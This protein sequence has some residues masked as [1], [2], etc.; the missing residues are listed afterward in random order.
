MVLGVIQHM[1]FVG[2]TMQAITEFKNPSAEAWTNKLSHLYNGVP[3]RHKGKH[4]TDTVT[5]MRVSDT[6][7]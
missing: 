1:N 3:C 2:D 6:N 7:E 4:V 5:W